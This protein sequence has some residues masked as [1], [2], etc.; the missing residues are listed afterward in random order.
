M[1]TVLRHR[2]RARRRHLRARRRGGR[3]RSAARSGPRSCSRACSRSSR[4]GS[5]AELVDE[6]PAGGGRRALRPPGVQ[7]G[8]L[9]LRGRL[10]GHGLRRHLRRD[11]RDRLRRRLPERVRRPARPCSS[12]SRSSSVIALINFRGIKESVGV[13]LGLTTIELRRPAARRG[14]RGRVPARRRRRARPRRSS[15]SP[16]S[17]SRS[18]S[19]AARRSR[20]SR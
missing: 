8:L 16:A 9:H 7:A 11:A 18:R 10:R 20:S 19:S 2:R 3:A 14:D 5:Y 15:S 12:G 17:R 6:V 13:N 4:R 1:L